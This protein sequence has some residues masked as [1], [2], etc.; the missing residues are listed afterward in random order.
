MISK[1]KHQLK[2]SYEMYTTTHEFL[3]WKIAA[4]KLILLQNEYYMQ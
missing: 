3:Q 4:N 1:D 2:S